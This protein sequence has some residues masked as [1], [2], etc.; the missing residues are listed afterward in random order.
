MLE[1][2]DKNI[3][4]ALVKCAKDVSKTLNEEVL[5]NVSASNVLLSLGGVT[6]KL[7]AVDINKGIEDIIKEEYRTKINQKMEHIR[8]VVNEKLTEVTSLIVNAKADFEDREEELKRKLREA[9]SMP[10]IT[11]RHM[12]AGLSVSRG[13]ER[14]MLAWVYQAVYAPKYVN[15]DLINPNYARKLVTPIRIII[16]TRGN[17]FLLI[18]TRK[19]VGSSLFEHYHQA[20]PDCWGDWR[21]KERTW[22][23]P[24]D[25]IRVAKEAEAIL[26]R[27]NRNSVAKRNPR[28]FPSLEAV[29]RNLLMNEI[30]QENKKSKP[31]YE[32]IRMGVIERNID[33]TENG[34]WST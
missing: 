5:S 4:D 6:F 27:I 18:S 8:N 28:G 7:E 11:F 12:E 30:M 22:N 25:I 32:D 16:L 9:L 20:N 19:L 14:D 23:T 1:S 15:N 3:R 34:V 21:Y 26:E 17:R 10:D 31:N 2:L 24:D 29:E 33:N 13:D